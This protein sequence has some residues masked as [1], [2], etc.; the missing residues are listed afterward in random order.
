MLGSHRSGNIVRCIVCVH[1]ADNETIL[2]ISVTK[3]VG[4]LKYVTKREGRQNG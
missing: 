2:N 3:Y 4:K 1:I